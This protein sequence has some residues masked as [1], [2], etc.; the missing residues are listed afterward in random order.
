M[1]MIDGHC[2]YGPGLNLADRANRL[3][4]TDEEWTNASRMLRTAGWAVNVLQALLPLLILGQVIIQNGH[5][6]SQVSKFI[7]AMRSATS[8]SLLSASSSA[9][10]AR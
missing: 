8:Y 10:S 7:S 5:G 1:R 3:E 9:K 6:I 4:I 2:L